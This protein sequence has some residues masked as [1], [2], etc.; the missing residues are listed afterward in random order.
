MN[1]FKKTLWLAAALLVVVGLVVLDEMENT[2]AAEASGTA[3]IDFQS[4]YVAIAKGFVDVEGGIVHLAAQR[5]GVVDEVLVEEGDFIQQGQ[6]L[7]TQLVQEAKLQHDRAR[8]EAE[9]VK[10][11]LVSLDIELKAA[12]RE[13]SRYQPLVDK[14]AAPGQHLDE[15]KDQATVLASQIK[16]QKAALATAQARLAEAEYE[17]EL[18]TIRAPLDGRIV[19]RLARPG[20]GLSTLNVSTLFWFVPETP[21]IVRAELEGRFVDRVSP[22][23]EARIVPESEESLSYTAKVKRVGLFFGPKRPSS[24]DPEER[25]DV[26]V[27]EVVLDLEKDTPLLLGQRVI[28]KFGAV[29]DE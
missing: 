11:G 17:I 14:Q 24:Y 9:E 5:D 4:P 27:V 25:A 12:R 20:A 28:V 21:R 7:A 6:V 19:K 8:A 1:G 15:L 26:R 23:M 13:I 3:A 2:G 16:T 22:G 18:R 29:S 10:A